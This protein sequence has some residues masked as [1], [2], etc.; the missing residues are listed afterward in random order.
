MRRLV[1]HREN[2]EPKGNRTTNRARLNVANRT[3]KVWRARVSVRGNPAGI[4]HILS[5]QLKRP[6]MIIEPG[7][8]VDCCVAPQ[9]G[10]RICDEPG[11]NLGGGE[12]VET[13]ADIAPGCANERVEALEPPPLV[14]AVQ[15]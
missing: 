12:I 14:V 8:Q 5:V 4:A 6:A 3:P 15:R 10:T 11:C 1:V 2:S 9:L 7:A 13:R